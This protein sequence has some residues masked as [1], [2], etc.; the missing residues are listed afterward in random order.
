VESTIYDGA[1]MASTPSSLVL[2]VATW[3][4]PD[5]FE[6]FA[7]SLRAT[8]Y[9][10]RLGMIL[11]H[12]DPATI[13]GFD[14]L[15]DFTVTVDD[16]Y[17][18][19]NSTLARL[20]GTVRTVRGVRRAYPRAFRLASRAG[21]STA[22]ARWSA[23]EFELEGLQ[24]LRY[25]HYYDVLQREGAAADQIL[26]TDMRDVLFQADP[27]EPQVEGLEVFLEEPHMTIADEW[28][29]HSWMLS[30]YG[31]EEVSELAQE[32]ASCSGTVAGD[33]ASMLRYLREMSQ[34]IV[35]RR[36]PLGNH[37]QGVHNHLLRTGRLDPVEIVAN[38]AGRVLTM[39]EMADIRRD[40]DGRVLNADG[41]LPAVL[42]QYDRHP[43]L[44]GE[45]VEQ[46]AG[47]RPKTR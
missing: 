29:T 18:R 37:D 9:K 3:L 35:W 6:P 14:E 46:L 17:E 16:S 21:E 15:A 28:F 25:D 43:G 5:Q 40:A 27:F 8:G 4:A 7:R 31:Q 33:R 42:H 38:G 13:C 22:L 2:G 11:G 45:L 26:L 1:T 41:S 30:L 20:L 47:P 10:G 34:A 32:V 44:A 23:L 12:Y 19:V 36:R 39:A 24:S